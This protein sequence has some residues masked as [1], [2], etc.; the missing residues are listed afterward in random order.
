MYLE[1]VVG[2]LAMSAEKCSG[3]EW[4]TGKAT[5]EKPGMILLRRRRWELLQEKDER[6]GKR[7]VGSEVSWHD[8]YPWDDQR[9]EPEH[10]FF[11]HA[12]ANTLPIR[13]FAA[14]EGA[15]TGRMY[16]GTAL[17]GIGGGKRCVTITRHEGKQRDVVAGPEQARL[18]VLRR[19][20]LTDREDPADL[21]QQYDGMR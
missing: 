17:R 21:A 7:E 11:R 14:S 9:A 3:R 16:Q 6:C 20:R 10:R 1:V 12:T 15:A 2:C 4:V 19:S 18:E 8:L 13:V 5:R